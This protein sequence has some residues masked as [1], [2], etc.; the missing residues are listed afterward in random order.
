MYIIIH[1]ALTIKVMLDGE[2]ESSSMDLSAYKRSYTLKQTELESMTEEDRRREMFALRTMHTVTA[3][4]TQSGDSFG[5][6]RASPVRLFTFTTTRTSEML[7][8]KKEEY[9]LLMRSVPEASDTQFK[10]NAFLKVS[11]PLKH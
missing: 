4:S 5:D 3:G 6:S 7:V 2:V 11:S 1:L 8:F 10:L 9:E